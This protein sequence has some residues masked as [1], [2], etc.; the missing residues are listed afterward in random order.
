M[1]KNKIYIIML[2]VIALG[3]SGTLWYMNDTR[4]EM[5]MIKE[6]LPQ[7]GKIKVIDG[8][9][10]NPVIKE[11]FPAIEKVYSIDNKPSAFIASSTGYEGI[12]KM[13]IVI[14]NEEEKIAGVRILI[15][16][17]TPLY[18]GPIE[19]EWFTDRFK[20]LGLLEYLN[21]VVLDPQKPTDIVQVTGASLTS[22]VVINNVNSAL[23][24]WNYLVANETKDP[25]DNFI[26][27]EMWQKDENSFELA[28]PDNNSIRITIDDLK[29]FNQ[30]STE[31]ILAK[32]N[33]VR[34]DIKASGAVLKDILKKKN[35]DINAYEAL[36]ITG[37]DNYYSMISKDIIE[38]RDIILATIVDGEEIPREEKPV[39]V[40][41]P[42]EMGPYWVKNVSKIELYTHISPKDI[43]NL[44]IFKALV[45][46]IEPYYYEYYG[47]QDES[48]LVGKIL[49]KFGN[50][51][52]N[53][54]FTMVASDGLIKNETIS[55]VRDRYYIKTAGNNA[56]MNI[57]PGFK[58]G[59]NVKEI[60]SFSTTT[61]GA[62]FPEIMIKVIEN[63]AL[64]QG[65]AIKLKETLE[66][67]LMELDGIDK[68]K[69]TDVNN[70]ETIINADQL[71]NA[72]LIPK[73]NG[74]DI[75]VD[76]ALIE[77]VLKI[78]KLED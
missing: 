51:D 72:Y 36:G 65:T 67:A 30:V 15:Q 23:G 3:V 17:D 68:L 76:S 43:Q 37:R 73:D 64:P 29:E 75:L 56:P 6:I 2:L 34:E 78:S 59:Y 40:V 61:D 8:A 39:R 22:Q 45:K 9:L 66:E 62:I 25:V 4:K 47:S 18:A 48:Y 11:N 50:V 46:D 24:A 44:Y 1:K 54:F 13:L 52:Q 49:A 16:G 35:I 19:E 7:A 21:R 26:S 63:E 5:A 27:Q 33:G 10:G 58:L 38:N 28:W 77:D 69:I 42:D 57:S 74:A 41:I 71:K 20:G 55:M 32:T 31:T 60:S 70:K 53:G 14:N 12:I